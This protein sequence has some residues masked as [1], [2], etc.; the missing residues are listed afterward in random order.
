MISRNLGQCVAVHIRHVGERHAGSE[1]DSGGRSEV[2]EGGVAG[3][4]L[5]ACPL[6]T[7]VTPTGLVLLARAFGRGVWVRFVLTDLRLTV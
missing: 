5:A 6:G 2:T 3:T 4:A 1:S 7:P